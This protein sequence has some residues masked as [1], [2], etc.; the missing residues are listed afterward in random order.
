MEHVVCGGS[1]HRDWAY[2]ISQSCL[3]YDIPGQ[4]CGASVICSRYDL[5]ASPTDSYLEEYIE[6]P[7]TLIT[8]FFSS[9][10]STFPKS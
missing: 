9:H 4:C 6:A 7:M 10:T 2:A 5:R 1:V 3:H 8:S